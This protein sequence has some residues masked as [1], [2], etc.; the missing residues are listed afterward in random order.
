MKDDD[1]YEERPRDKGGRNKMLK[2]ER[3]TRGFVS[4]VIVIAD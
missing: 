2:R 4:S 1:K 3:R